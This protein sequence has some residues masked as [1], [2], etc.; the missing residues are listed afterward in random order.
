MDKSLSKIIQ[1]ALFTVFFVMGSLTTIIFVYIANF[2]TVNCKAKY[3]QVITQQNLP[4][5]YGM[6]YKE[7]YN[8]QKRERGWETYIDLVNGYLFNYPNHYILQNNFST[9]GNVSLK[10]R[11][12]KDKHILYDDSVQIYLAS[13]KKN[14]IDAKSKLIDF[15][16]EDTIRV[17]KYQTES[18]FHQNMING[19]EV[20]IAD[21]EMTDTQHKIEKANLPSLKDKYELEPVG[22]KDKT[23]YIKRGNDIFIFRSGNLFDKYQID[24]FNK[25]ILSFKFIY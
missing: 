6:K 13:I 20:I 14:S 22:Y 23:A 1:V 18:T 9:P 8:V 17:P 12:G 5:N 10:I 19:N 15:V 3:E 11:S 16:K 7:I 24:T 21:F 4:I 25:I 2:S